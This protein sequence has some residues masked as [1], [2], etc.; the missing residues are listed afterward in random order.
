M[1]PM[2]ITPTVAP[3]LLPPTQQHRLLAGAPWRRLVVMGDS[4]AAGVGD[5]TPGYPDR[6]WADQ[7]ADALA[8]INADLVYR[9]LGVRGLKSDEILTTQLSPAV[10]F[11]PDLAVVSAG[12]NDILGN[13]FDPDLTERRL[14]AIVSSLAH[15]GAQVVTFSLFDLSATPFVPDELRAGL[16]ARLHELASITERISAAHDGIHVDYLSDPRSGDP[17]MY[18]EDRLHVNRRGHAVVLTSM[19]EALG[20]ALGNPLARE[21]DHGSPDS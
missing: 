11:G 14:E 16:R 6:P 15:C 4:I 12:G 3:D 8:T 2:T 13:R 19:V 5:P 7:L 18:S 21:V 1:S 10:E 17:A 20:A 9:N